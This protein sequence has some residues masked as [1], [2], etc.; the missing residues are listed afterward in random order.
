VALGFT[1]AV[2]VYLALLALL[3]LT[4]HGGPTPQDSPS[5]IVSLTPWIQRHVAPAK[6]R[7]API[8][9]H[10]TPAP[11]APVP[12]APIPP[13][14]SK[15]LEPNAPMDPKLATQ[16]AVAAALR[17]NLGCSH[18]DDVRTDPAERERCLK[19]QRQLG[20]GAPVY[21]V[22]I[23]DHARHDPPVAGHGMA[24]VQHLSPRPGYLLGTPGPAGCYHAWC[25][26]EDQIRG[27][28]MSAPPN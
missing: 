11:T 7:P 4:I 21:T 10:Q 20:Q 5:I 8:V 22:N 25:H 15:P 19:L 28:A 14:P 6:A 17:A 16:G 1:A 13:T 12:L 23:D 3:L 24:V 2:V 27:P 18:L 9:A 26:E